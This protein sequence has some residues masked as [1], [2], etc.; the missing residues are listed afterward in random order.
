MRATR[1]QLAPL[2]VSV[3]SLA[4][5]ALA[6]SGAASANLE[7]TS[8]AFKAGGTIPRV[9]TCAGANHS[10][11]LAWQG[12]PAGTKSFALIVKDPD[13]PGRA[14]IHWVVYNIP[15]G[16]HH[17]AANVAKTATTGEGASQGS[18]SRGTLGFAGPCP[19]PGPPHH[20]HF[21]LFALDAKLSLR[22]G[23]TAPELQGAM[24]DHVLARSE[25]V[26]TF[27]R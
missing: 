20:Y 2:M 9:Y 1:S 19:P 6:A 4:I 27:G 22:P 23:A 14:F 16:V 15:A 17:L 10:P 13:A 24:K 8:E 5:V 21:Q 26:A 7:L 18:N 25:L 11:P 12:A 3:F